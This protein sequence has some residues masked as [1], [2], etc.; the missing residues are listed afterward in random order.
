MK[1]KLKILMAASEMAPLAKVGGLADVVGSLPPALINLGCDVRVALPAY[2][3]IDKKKIKAKKILTGVN[4][5]SG[6][7]NLKINV[8]RVKIN[9]LTVYL[10]DCPKYFGGREIYKGG[11]KFYNGDKDSERFLFFSLA[12]LQAL[13][14]LKFQPDIIHTHDFHTALIPNLIKASK[15]PFFKNIKTLYTIHNLNHQGKSEIGILSTG[16]LKKDSSKFLSRDAQDG[17][18]NFMVQGIVSSDLANTVSPTYAKEI[19]TSIYGAGIE[20]VIRQNQNKISG[21]LNGIDV[22]FFDPAKDKYI[23]ENYT[24][25]TLDKKTGNKLALQK[26]LGLKQDKNIPL[27]GLISRLAWQKGL[28][29]FAEEAAKLPCQ[30]VFLGT[31]E[32][33]YEDQLKKLAK[34]YPNKISAQITFDIRLAQLIYAA[35]DIFL[36]PSRFEPCGLGQMIAMRYGAVPIV[37][38]TG[39]LADTVDKKVGFSFFNFSSQAFAKTLEETLNIYYKKP[40]KWKKMQKRGMKKDFSWNKSAKEYLKL[41]K[42]LV[43]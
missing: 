26:Q 32:K 7:K 8:W 38:A 19:A 39:G 14:E 29:L 22:N 17:D 16:N 21:I 5:K 30:F 1:N 11:K 20:K 35:S 27:A 33:K 6:G 31:G 25:K 10:L 23:K 18:I 12:V 41:Y 43:G 36:M 13:P 42:K 15:D 4:I 37:R 2:G 28:E 9:G 3:S 24:Y 40:R 34:I